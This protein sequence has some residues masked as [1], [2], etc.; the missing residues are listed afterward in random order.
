MWT[1]GCWKRSSRRWGRR[2]GSGL[3]LVAVGGYGRKE[4]F[5]QADVDL[6]LLTTTDAVA[7]PREAIAD[8]LQLLWDAGCGRA[9][10]CIAFRSAPRSIPTTRS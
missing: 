3:A 7:P 5:P 9:I 2:M 10:R 1:G 6:L 8:F 4:L